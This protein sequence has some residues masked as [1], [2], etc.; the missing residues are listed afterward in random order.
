[1]FP[2]GVDL[3][4]RTNN[5]NIEEFLLWDTTS[6]PILYDGINPIYWV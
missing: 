2:F 3:Y 4:Y 6:D 1:M 5:H